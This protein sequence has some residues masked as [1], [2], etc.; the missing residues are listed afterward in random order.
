MLSIRQIQP[1]VPRTNVRGIGDYQP[2][3][4]IIREGFRVVPVAGS[5]G[6]S[7]TFPELREVCVH[8]GE[9]TLELRVSFF[10]SV[11]EFVYQFL[12]R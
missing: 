10:A 5:Y 6:I 2:V 8:G 1:G 12:V 9:F 11:V 3:L 4:H 7:E